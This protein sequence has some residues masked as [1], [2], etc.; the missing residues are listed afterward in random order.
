MGKASQNRSETPGQLKPEKQS[1]WAGE[2]VE[3]LRTSATAGG[4][5]K[6]ENKLHLF[7]DDMILCT[8]NAKK[9]SEKLVR[10]NKLSKV[11]KHT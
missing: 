7:V 1:N 6:E 4:N 9:S 10:T 3:Q 11:I 5:E 2:E 8:E